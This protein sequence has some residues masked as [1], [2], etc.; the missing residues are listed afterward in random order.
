MAV[1]S[2]QDGFLMDGVNVQ[3]SVHVPEGQVEC[4]G[5]DE[6]LGSVG[7]QDDTFRVV[8]WTEVN[9]PTVELES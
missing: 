4:L 1:C 6:N 2:S 7:V 3:G 9:T 5:S 8:D